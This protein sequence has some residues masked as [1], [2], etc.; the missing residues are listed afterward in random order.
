MYY[1]YISYFGQGTVYYPWLLQMKDWKEAI[2]SMGFQRCFYEK[3]EHLHC[4]AFRKITDNTSEGISDTLEAK[5]YIPQDFNTEVS[6]E[7]SDVEHSPQTKRKKLQTW[8]WNLL[9]SS[10][11]EGQLVLGPK[12]WCEKECPEAQKYSYI[13]MTS[14]IIMS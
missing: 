1:I 9:S 12:I 14:F 11:C 10:D 13:N 3:K 6:S 5:M 4:M 2:E 7:S 8:V